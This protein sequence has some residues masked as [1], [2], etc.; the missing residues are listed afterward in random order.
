MSDFASDARVRVSIQGLPFPAGVSV[1]DGPTVTPRG[2]E[3]SGEDAEKV[4]A[5]LKKHPQVGEDNVQVSV[6]EPGTQP[7]SATLEDAVGEQT[8]ADLREQ[9]DGVDTL[10]DA[11]ETPSEQLQAVKG[12]GDKT[13]E[14]IREAETEVP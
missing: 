1:D 9:V 8:A 4:I 5:S 6:V 7:S 10:Q 12:V 3:T 2:V 11:K 14:K 13:V